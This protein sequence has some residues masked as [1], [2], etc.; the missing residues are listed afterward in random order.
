MSEIWFE[1]SAA[2]DEFAQEMSLKELKVCLSFYRKLIA[3]QDLKSRNLNA[4]LQ[5][6]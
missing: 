6:P 4:L 3:W 5:N 1:I 2:D